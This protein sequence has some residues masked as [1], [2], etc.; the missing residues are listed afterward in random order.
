MDNSKS[1]FLVSNNKDKRPLK[2]LVPNLP[3]GKRGQDWITVHQKTYNTAHYTPLLE[4]LKY[5]H[6]R[7]DFRL[8]AG[9]VDE[10]ND[11]F[12]ESM[13]NNLIATKPFSLSPSIAWGQ[14]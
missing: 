4:A 9:G 14:N 11:P 2:D 6:S 12:N 7:G 5:A 13:A 8:C 1:A 3:M 10:V